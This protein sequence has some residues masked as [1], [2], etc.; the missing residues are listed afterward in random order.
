M[1]HAESNHER[2]AAEAPRPMS[3]AEPDELRNRI[4]PQ[5][6][7]KCS[8]RTL[9]RL[10]RAGLVLQTRGGGDEANEQ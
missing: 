9:R 1:L 2:L 10:A 6:K 7:V 4:V 3:I 8:K 5:A